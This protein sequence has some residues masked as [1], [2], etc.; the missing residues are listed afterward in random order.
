MCIVGDFGTRVCAILVVHFGGVV[1]VH[2]FGRQKAA[3]DNPGPVGSPPASDAFR[4]LWRRTAL[5]LVPGVLVLVV[6]LV[7]AWETAGNR[8]TLF[9]D[10]MI[11][12]SYGRTLA[13]TGQW[14]WFPG[15]A[16]VQ[17]FTNPLWTLY[18]ALLHLLGLNE[19]AAVAV[20]S[21]TGILLLTCTAFVVAFIVWISLPKTP[22][23]TWCA[24][25]AAATVP[26]LFSLSFWSLRGMEVGA[27]ALLSLMLVAGAVWLHRRAQLGGSL[28]GPLV[29]ISLVEAL[30]LLTRLDFM[31]VVV[32]VVILLYLWLPNRAVHRWVL[33]VPASVAAACAAVILTFQWAYFGDPL[34]NTYRLKME[35]FSIGDR[36][37]RG[38]ATL[39][40][41]VP[42]SVLAAIALLIVF[43]RQ[44]LDRT[45]FA[46]AMLAYT[47]FGVLSYSVWVGGDAWEWSKMANRFVSV[48]LPAATA[49]IFIGVGAFLSRPA[50]HALVAPLMLGIFVASGITMSAMTNPFG[51]NS[52]LGWQQVQYLAVVAGLLFVAAIAYARN[53]ETSAYA[54]ALIACVSAAI[55]VST[56]AIAWTTWLRYDG[57]HV[58]DDGRITALAL[59]LR[60]ATD[61]DAVIATMWAGAPGYYARRPMVDLLGKSDPVIASSKPVVLAPSDPA[62]TFYPGHNKWDLDYSLGVLRPDVVY[63]VPESEASNLERLAKWGYVRR[64]WSDGVTESFFRIDSASIRWEL[65]SPCSLDEP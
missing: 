56:S 59:E 23:S 12:M 21:V 4:K 19:E 57:P 40:P 1:L 20:V 2:G 51:F 34:T 30:G 65:L 58:R 64:C 25:F 39:G 24:V 53:R 15:G 54:T 27:L 11:S 13:E 28:I 49:L 31:V 37:V 46:A 26:F 61:V 10:A 38:F 44:S 55:V 36:I 32:G 33:V 6:L 14:T 43:G 7:R 8:F 18:M 47:W 3:K 52:D 60:E 41:G 63:Q 35:G 48:A 45:R 42:L 62:S 22:R 5:S 29:L 16:R 17:G 50:R 9:D